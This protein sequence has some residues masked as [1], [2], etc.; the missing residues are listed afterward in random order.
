MR[1]NLKATRILLIDTFLVLAI[2][3]ILVTLN[4]HLF[5]RVNSSLTEIDQTRLHK[6][7]LVGRMKKIIRD[8]SL[9][10][11]D[12]ASEHDVWAFQDKYF[13]FHRIANEF[14]SARKEFVE[15]GLTPPENEKL[16]KALTTITQ[17]HCRTRL[18]SVFV[19]H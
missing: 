18:L 16:E 13:K 14:I 8:R 1:S 9:V 4:L 2:S 3:I 5:N 12:M 11:L 17:N 15:I 7:V 10:M 6:L 19:S